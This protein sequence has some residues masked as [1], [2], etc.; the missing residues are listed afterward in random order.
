MGE[1]NTLKSGASSDSGVLKFFAEIDEGLNSYNQ[2]IDLLNR[3]A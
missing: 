2:N 3:G 1:F